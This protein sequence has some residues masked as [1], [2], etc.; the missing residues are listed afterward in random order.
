MADAQYYTQEAANEKAVNIQTAL[1]ASKVRLVQAPYIPGPN[2]V[3]ADLVANEATYDG[4]TSGGY[5]LAAWTGPLN[6]TPNGALL[7]SPLINFA[8]GPAGTPPVTNSITGG[9][10]EDATGHV[11]FVFTYNPARTMSAVGNGWPFVGQLVEGQNAT[12]S[13]G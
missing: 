2:S 6:A 11:R 7:T 13:P 9:W 10:V 3:K 5:A 1:V 4:Y 12:S 8:Y